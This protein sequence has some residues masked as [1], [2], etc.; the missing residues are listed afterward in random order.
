MRLVLALIL[1]ATPAVADTVV[2]SRTIRSLSLIG[3]ED[4]SIVPGDIPGSA[5][6]IDEVVGQEA[7]VMLYPGRPVMLDQI[8]PPALIERNQI[9]SITFRAG[10]LQITA[11]GRALAR[12]GLGDEVR[13]M[14]LDSKKTVTGR[15]TKDGTVAVG[16][17]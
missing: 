6:S 7:R 1:L 5:I 11:E 9:V 16:A 17:P 4:L 2:T 12:G 14:N 3:P 13:V 8:G 15:V 10:A